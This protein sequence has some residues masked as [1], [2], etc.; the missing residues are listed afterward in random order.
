MRTEGLQGVGDAVLGCEQ[1]T[2]R[3][4]LSSHLLRNAVQSTAQQLRHEQVLR[5][6]KS[7]PSAAWIQRRKGRPGEPAHHRRALHQ[8]A[9]VRDQGD[10]DLRLGQLPWGR[11]WS[12][13]S[14]PGSLHLHH[15]GVHPVRHPEHREGVLRTAWRGQEARSHPTEQLVEGIL[16]SRG[17]RA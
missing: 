11:G 16:E 15:H 5:G 14:L 9:G 2:N 6:G 12:P 13:G 4:Q 1:G 7:N 3:L 17:H 8:H 10:R